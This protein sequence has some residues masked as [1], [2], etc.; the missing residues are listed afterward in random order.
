MFLSIVKR[1]VFEPM[2]KKDWITVVIEELSF[3][4][5]YS[6][7]TD[8][9]PVKAVAIALYVIEKRT[10]RALDFRKLIREAYPDE[11]NARWQA[12]HCNR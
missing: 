12:N 10:G 9:S 8:V 3:A 1:R 4:K 11:N 6:K 7:E 2:G 5:K